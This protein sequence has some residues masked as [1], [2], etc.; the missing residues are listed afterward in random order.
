M[1]QSNKHATLRGVWKRCNAVHVCTKLAVNNLGKRASESFCSIAA[2]LLHWAA[3]N[4]QSVQECFL[5]NFF[6]S[7]AVQA[8]CCTS[9]SQ[10]G[11][12]QL[13]IVGLQR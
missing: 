11:C 2:S 10:Q 3:A 5:S 12:T 4:S 8:K 9:M 6:V 1:G 13:K 7:T